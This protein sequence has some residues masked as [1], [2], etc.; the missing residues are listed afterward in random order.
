MVRFLTIISLI[1][2]GCDG[3]ET[4]DLAPTQTVPDDII[5]VIN[6]DEPARHSVSRTEPPV[7][8]SEIG[9]LSEPVIVNA[10]MC[11]PDRKRCFWGD[12][13]EICQLAGQA[14]VIFH[15]TAEQGYVSLWSDREATN[16]LLA[17]I[18][19]SG[20]G[21]RVFE[22]ADHR[23]RLTL[24]VSSTN[25]SRGRAIG[26]GLVGEMVVE[27]DGKKIPYPYPTPQTNIQGPI[28][29]RKIADIV[30]IM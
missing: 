8:V 16:L 11:S 7:F 18:S 26:S 28:D 15:Y 6:P 10:E 30:R 9:D 4:R 5:P 25:Q 3:P 29:C 27:L 14:E 22:S 13:E 20:S 1:L 17:D 23:L 21:T 12:T 19:T 24:G 2:A